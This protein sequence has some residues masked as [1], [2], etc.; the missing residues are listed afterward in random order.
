VQIAT[1]ATLTFNNAALI[2]GNS[3]S[4]R[5]RATDAAGNLSA[6]SPIATGT[7]TDAT[8]PTVPAGLFAMA[9]GPG[10]ISLTWTTST[11]ASNVIQYQIERCQGVGCSTFSPVTIT[12]LTSFTDTGLAANMPYSYRAR[13][14]DGANNVSTYSATVSVTTFLAPPPPSTGYGILA[15]G[16][17]RYGE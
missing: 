13:A 6:Y 5:V 10:Q 8:A 1:T 14:I 11:D 17:G 16:T 15:Y 2:Q 9:Q 3:Y 12:V 7:T 4:Y